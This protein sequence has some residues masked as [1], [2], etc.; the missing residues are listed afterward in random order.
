MWA[1]DVYGPAQQ[2]YDDDVEGPGGLVTEERHISIETGSRK[3]LPLLFLSRHHF[4]TSAVVSYGLWILRSIAA[5]SVSLGV[6]Q[7]GAV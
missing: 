3:Q 6:L 2:C 7:G 5:S 4:V 1:E